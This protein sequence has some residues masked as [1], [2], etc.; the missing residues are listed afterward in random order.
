VA[1]FFLA[2]W[3]LGCGACQCG[4]DRVLLAAPLAL[5]ALGRFLQ[6]HWPSEPF[7]VLS[8]S[9]QE[10]RAER[11]EGQRKRMR[12]SVDR[13]VDGLFPPKVSHS[14]PPILLSITIQDFFPITASWNSDSVL[15][16]RYRRKVAHN[17][18]SI[19]GGFSVAQEREHARSG[20]IAINPLKT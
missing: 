13:L 1:R 20:V 4:A 7:G 12:P 8:R 16:S 5:V 10:K 14:A 17:D 19:I 18:Q 3:S 2:L 6:L 15:E 11:R 9:F